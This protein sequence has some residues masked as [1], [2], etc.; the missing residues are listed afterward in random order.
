M[1][2]VN[3]AGRGSEVEDSVYGVELGYILRKDPVTVPPEPER[4][5]TVGREAIVINL[6]S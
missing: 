5:Q 4:T 2:A 1:G 6:K 3:T